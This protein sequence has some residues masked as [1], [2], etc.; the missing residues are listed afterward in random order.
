[1]EY[2]RIEV[3]VSGVESTGTHESAGEAGAGLLEVRWIRRGVGEGGTEPR[4]GLSALVGWRR[5]EVTSLKR[6]DPSEEGVESNDSGSENGSG[7][8]EGGLFG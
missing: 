8:S 1:M 3:G 7:L 5:D 4:D 6:G 2:D